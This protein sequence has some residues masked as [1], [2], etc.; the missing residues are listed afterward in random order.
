MTLRTLR[1]L[2]IA[3]LGSTVILV[4]V[5]MMVLP[6]P[7]VLVIPAGLAILASEFAWARHMLR[8]IKAQLGMDDPDSQPSAARSDPQ[9]SG[10]GARAAHGDRERN[11]G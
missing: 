5:A 8:R 7:A 9:A 2:V 10:R 11:P 1:R 4:G 6:G 3:L